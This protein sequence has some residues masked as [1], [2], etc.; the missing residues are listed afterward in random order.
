MASCLFSL[1]HVRILNHTKREIMKTTR[2]ITFIGFLLLIS[3]FSYAKSAIKGGTTEQS[4]FNRIGMEAA[5][6]VSCIHRK[7]A[8][9]GLSI[10][11]RV[12]TKAYLYA[13]IME[14]E[15]CPPFSN[16]YENEYNEISDHD[17]GD[18]VWGTSGE[19]QIPDSHHCDVDEPVT[20]K[21]CNLDPFTEGACE[22]NPI[23]VNNDDPD[24]HTCDFGLGHPPY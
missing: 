5:G 10:G 4:T 19:H 16:E 1:Y 9:T 7:N 22:Q 18:V 3:I 24:D 14:G 15:I 17:L 2:Q 11:I 8:R 6:L 20:T 12:D 21:A 13:L 23:C